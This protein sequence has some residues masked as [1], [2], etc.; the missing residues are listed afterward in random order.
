MCSWWDVSQALA[1]GTSMVSSCLWLI[2]DRWTVTS[3]KVVL[4]VNGPRPALD[5]SAGFAAAVLQDQLLVGLLDEGSEEPAPD[6]KAGLMDERLDLVGEVLVLDGTGRDI[7][8][9]SCS[10]KA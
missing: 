5:T 8:S 9:D 2:R 6:L 4:K 10:E 3:P 7:P 1:E